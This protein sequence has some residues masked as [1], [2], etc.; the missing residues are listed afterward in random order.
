MTRSIPSVSVNFLQHTARQSNELGMR[1]M[2]ERVYAK[3]GEQYLLIKSPPA[4]GKSRALMF[5]A[6][7]KLHNQGVKKAI[8]V[9]PEK[10]IG[11]SFHDEPLSQFGFWADFRGDSVAVLAPQDEAKFDTVTYTYYEQLSGYQY[12][13][14]LDIGYFF[15]SGSYADSIAQVLDT[16]Q[17]TIV[18]IPN[19]NSRESSKD[20]IREVEHILEQ[21]GTWQGTDETTGFQLVQTADGRV[22]K[23][24]DLVDDDPLKRDR[25]SAALKDPTQKNNRNHVD[26]IIAL[27][28]A[29]E[30]FDWIWCEH[31]LTV[32]Y[33]ASLT[34]IVQ[35][36]GRATRDAPGKTRARFTN[37]IAEPDAEESAVAEAIND[38]LKAIAASLLME[39]VLTPRYEFR[40]KN[41]NNTPSENFDYGDAGYQAGKTNV[42]FN[43]NTGTIQMEIAGL[44]EPKSEAAQRICQEDLN[45]VIAA[46]VQD[47]TTIERGLFD[48]DLIPEELTQIKMGK[49]IR[50]KYPELDGEDI[51]AVRQRAVAALNLTQQA[52]QVAN[53]AAEEDGKDE[54]ANL[55]LI[56]GV[57]K[58]AMDVRELDID[59]IDRINPFAE[60]YAI[61]AKG[62][63]EA[64]LQQVAAMITGKRTKLDP[65]EAK[66]LA[67]RAKHFQQERGRWPSATAQDPWEQ[68]LENE[69]A[70]NSITQLKNVRPYQERREALLAEYVAQ[71]KPCEDFEQFEPLFGQI[72]Q[73]LKLGTYRT[74][75]FGGGEINAG[76]FFILNGQ[77]V[78]VAHI[79]EKTQNRNGTFNARM[80]VILDNRTESDLINRSLERALYKDKNGRRIVATTPDLNLSLDFG[81][82]EEEDDIASGTIYVARSLSDDPFIRANRELV[83]KIGVTGGK[84]Q[85]R[86]ANAALDATFLLADVEVVAEYK[87]ANINRTKFEKIL[88]TLFAPARLTIT[89]SDRFGNPVEPKEWFLVPLNVID[90]AIQAI[91]DGRGNHI[92]YDVENARLITILA[93]ECQQPSS[94]NG[95]LW[96]QQRQRFE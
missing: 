92:A 80:R 76:D 25:V 91:I 37:L 79:G 24:A 6:L 29:K 18:H 22:L 55:A 40:P 57:R 48:E 49:I 13:K 86:I 42:G 60:A 23:I 3:R 53:R 78:F 45:E 84:V 65:E 63:N 77:T 71:Y 20:K 85:T 54:K 27:G 16:H 19:V 8:I 46:F 26:I 31:A 1:P 56:E 21:I 50:D 88:H 51:E 73:G 5:V 64:N 12:L 43:P 67:I 14:Q 39:Q 11:S 61:L 72:K 96:Q 2:Q 94:G 41:P 7:D 66:M 4:S 35:I 74:E 10:S 62:M 32:G 68:K 44:A 47:K 33:R 81:S 75:P 34:E 28:M 69:F 36:I 15:Y 59:L 38:T 90:E 52:K 70:E 95:Q 30:G 17:K 93:C 87:L 82:K 9:V 58:F 89:I 83:H